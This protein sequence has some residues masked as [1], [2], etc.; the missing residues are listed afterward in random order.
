M[1]VSDGFK[2]LEESDS[3]ILKVILKREGGT[4]FRAVIWIDGERE[5]KE[6][7]EAI[8]V[9]EASRDTPDINKEG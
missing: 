6:L 5:V 4:P 3:A 8:E 9:I 7:I 2:V 1:N